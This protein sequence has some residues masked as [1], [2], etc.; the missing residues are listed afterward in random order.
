M[1]A[2]QL[3][4]TFWVAFIFGRFSGT[5]ISTKVRPSILI[6]VYFVGSIAGVSIVIA[7]DAT[8]NDS[9][10]LLYSAVAIFGLFVSTRSFQILVIP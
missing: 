7:L 3:N 6:A 2:N 4:M 9:V 5:A 1:D 8:R 10:A